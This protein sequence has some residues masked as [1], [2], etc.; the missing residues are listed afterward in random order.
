MQRIVVDSMMFRKIVFFS[1]FLFELVC[2]ATGK[3]ENSR[4]RRILFSSQKFRFRMFSENI[5]KPQKLHV[6]ILPASQPHP[7]IQ[8]L[9]HSSDFWSVRM[10]APHERF[11][12]ARR[13]KGS[14]K[15]TDGRCLIVKRNGGFSKSEHT[16]N[17]CIF[18]SNTR[19]KKSLRRRFPFAPFRS[20]RGVR[21]CKCVCASLRRLR[22]MLE[23]SGFVL[24]PQKRN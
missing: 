6:K 1:L 23:L 2:R 19:R 22:E 10:C 21:A 5:L 24:D 7:H 9:P 15:A 8:L 17:M 14:N 12:C 11:F 16:E 20:W 3:R 13:T 18:F 4:V